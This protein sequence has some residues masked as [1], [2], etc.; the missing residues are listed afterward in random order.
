MYSQ[1]DTLNKLTTT[2][3]KTG[4][5]KIY[6]NEHFELA[7]DSSKA[8]YCDYEQYING[9]VFRYIYDKKDRN[10]LKIKYLP[11]DPLKD[12]KLLNGE[13]LY[14]NKSNNLS[15]KDEFIKGV[16]TKMHTY[17]Y[18]LDTEKKY[19]LYHEE[20]I[21]FTRPYNNSNNSYY[22]EI[23]DYK[24]LRDTWK[25]KKGYVIFTSYRKQKTIKL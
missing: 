3:K 21:D 25:I 18:F 4:Y 13:V 1:P 11:K 17:S 2:G 19:V 14:Y 24:V 16:I 20:L 23:K 10:E 5:W 12:G 6:Y 8:R 15:Y 9:D 7:P 22:F